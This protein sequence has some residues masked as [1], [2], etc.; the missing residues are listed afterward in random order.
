[1]VAYLQGVCTYFTICHHY[2]HA[3][4]LH[5]FLIPLINENNNVNEPTK[6]ERNKELIT[7]KKFYQYFT[8]FQVAVTRRVAARFLRNHT[9]PFGFFAIKGNP[10]RAK[11]LHHL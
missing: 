7:T 5:F 9:D 1:V 3:I 10:I 11:I 4:F 2:S 8:A 6:K